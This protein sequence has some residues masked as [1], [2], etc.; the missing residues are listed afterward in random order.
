M[1]GELKFFDTDLA[2]SFD[3]TGEVPATGQ[4]ALIPQGDTQSTRDGRQAVVKSIQVYGYLSLAP[5][6]AA[7]VSVI[8][9]LY[10][11]LDR[12][13][14]GA[15]AAITDVFTSNDMGIALVNINNSGRFRILKRWAIEMNTPAGVSGAY[16]SY[17]KCL[18][19]YEACNYLLDW[20][21]T[22]GAI[23]ELRSN[24]LFLC[25]GAQGGAAD[26]TVSF[27]GTCRLR[28]VG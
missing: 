8:A 12:Q 24:N 4:L 27:A 10:L 14:N 3:V 20:S 13:A 28:F 15:A 23:T 7:A 25:A 16:N 17:I 6:A 22:T 5:A 19:F 2:F 26:D 21:G 1:S 11:V 9:Y 18:E